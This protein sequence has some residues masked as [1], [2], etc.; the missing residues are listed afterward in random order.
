M[1]EAVKQ[2]ASTILHKHYCEN[3]VEFVIRTFAPDITWIGAGDG[4]H[5]DSYD[6][7]VDFFRKCKGAIPPCRIWGEEYHVTLLTQNLYLCDG[8]AWIATDEKENM[9]IKVR[10]RVSFLF[11]W[12]GGKLE[13]V[14]IHCSNPYQEM[15]EGE[16]FPDKV[17]KTTYE[18]VQE[19]IQDVKNVEIVL[20]AISGGLKISRDDATYSYAYVSDELCA[21][22]GY[23]KE[24]FF[25]ATD[26]SAV[27]AV[28]PPDLPRALPRCV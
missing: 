22:F 12:T 28:F 15:A 10:Q 5:L 20:N 23:T 24:E 16:L 27:G 11:R 25:K 17:G 13:C 14:H 26:G 6:E 21:M 4:Q 9:L 1:I 2:L 7:I 18:Y 19:K 3:D 8:E